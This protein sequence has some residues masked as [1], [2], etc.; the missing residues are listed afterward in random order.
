MKELVEQIVKAMV[1][2]PSA[3]EIQEV[4]GETTIVIELRVAKEDAGKIIGRKGRNAEAIRTILS[5]AGA[6]AKKKVELQILEW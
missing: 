6:K 5:A 2:Y 1:D 3:V 4:R